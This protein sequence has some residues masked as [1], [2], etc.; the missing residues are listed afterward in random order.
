MINTITRLANAYWQA[1]IELAA[2][3]PHRPVSADRI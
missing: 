2:H 1:A 3:D